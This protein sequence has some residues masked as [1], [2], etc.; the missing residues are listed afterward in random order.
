MCLDYQKKTLEKTGI[1]LYHTLAIPALIHGSENCT[2]TAKDARS[3]R[4]QR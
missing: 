2:T 4:Q 1:K 3:K